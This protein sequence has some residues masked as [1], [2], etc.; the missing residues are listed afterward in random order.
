MEVYPDRPDKNTNRQIDKLIK[1]PLSLGEIKP[2]THMVNDT[3]II[4]NS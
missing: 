2:N 3:N 1:D 4:K